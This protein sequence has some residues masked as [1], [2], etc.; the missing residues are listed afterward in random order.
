[1]F[2][3]K[4]KFINEC[5]IEG[6]IKANR[7][8]N[9]KYVITTVA[10]ISF[11]VLLFVTLF[12]SEIKLSS[13]IWWF[14]VYGTMISY[15]PYMIYT[16]NTVLRGIK[17][18]KI[19]FSKFQ[20]GSASVREYF[21]EKKQIVLD[22]IFKSKN[23]EINFDMID[24]YLEWSKE[25]EEKNKYDGLF[26][27]ALLA[28]LFLPIWSKS[29][30]VIFEAINQES[31]MGIQQYLLLILGITILIASLIMILKNSIATFYLDWHNSER[32]EFQIFRNSLLEYKAKNKFQ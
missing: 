1:M 21:K 8:K 24:F 22:S 26:E 15:I 25:N 16:S 2:E 10:Y 30:D 7:W 23:G 20:I 19:K 13:N 32:K 11:L 14:V 17:D 3:N 18:K 6:Y 5:T 28:G 4:N 29:V 12:V 27:K 9:K 31:Q